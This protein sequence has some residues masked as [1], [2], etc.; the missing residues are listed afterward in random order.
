MDRRH[1]VRS[2][3]IALALPML[4]SFAGD[5]ELASQ[6]PPVKRLVAI[7]SYLGFHTPSWFPRQAGGDYTISEVLAP[8]DD[9]RHDFTLFSGLDPSDHGAV[10]FLD[11]HPFNVHPLEQT[12][13]TLAEA[14]QRVLVDRS[15][16]QRLVQAGLQRADDFAMGKLAAAYV[17]IYEELAGAQQRR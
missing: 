7:G 12:H 17:E 3:G 6:A 11:L 16:S 14:L 9:L 2:P 8:I 15:L 4:E 1:F 13:L 10:T 5:A